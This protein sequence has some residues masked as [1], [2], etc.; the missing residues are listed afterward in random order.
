MR[1]VLALALL[2][3]VN[4]FWG[5]SYVVAKV[6][7]TE[8]PPPLLAALRFTLAALVL[9]MV[10]GLRARTVRLPPQRDTFKLL[11][12]G[13][14]GVA[15]N[16]L[17][18][19]WGISLTTATDS[20]LMIVGEVI[21]TT[22]LAL[23]LAGEHQSRLR[24]LGLVTGLV[25][26]IVLI[27]GGGGDPTVSAPSRPLGDVLILSGLA[28][29][30]LYTVLGTRLTHRH[31]PLAVL[32]LSF[33]GSCIVWLPVIVWYLAFGGVSMPSSTAVAGVVYL[34]LVTS[35]ACY[36]VWFNVLRRAGATLGAISLLAQPVVGA[37]L[38]IIVMGDP[39]L[40]STLIGG[41]CV[42]VCTALAPNRGR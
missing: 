42:L 4:A 17:L 20:A 7:L 38:G 5:A 37:A 25:G 29:E 16:G 13:V 27:V 11:G 14:L 15:V 26:V 30:S 18:G 36:L 32:T 22:L 1:P 6:A 10:I 23:A 35:V 40:P 41:A 31:E 8:I 9:W 21:F 33:T 24:G 2:V 39:V 3:V 34:A 12:L 28:F 19:F